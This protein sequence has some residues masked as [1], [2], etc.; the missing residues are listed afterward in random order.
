MVNDWVATL[1]CDRGGDQNPNGR[2]PREGEMGRHQAGKR[3]KYE[4]ATVRKK[5]KCL[6]DIPAPTL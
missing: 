5:P 2:R 1:K 6:C 3:S 4:A